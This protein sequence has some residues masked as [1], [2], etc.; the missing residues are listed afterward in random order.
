M[1]K[2][3]VQEGKEAKKKASALKVEESSIRRQIT[4]HGGLRL[5]TEN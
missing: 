1:G 3:D 4:K 5:G 2:R